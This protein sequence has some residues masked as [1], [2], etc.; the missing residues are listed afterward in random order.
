M[1]TIAKIHNSLSKENI[2][3]SAISWNGFNI[4]GDEKSIKEVKRLMH[5]AGCAA[6]LREMYQ[7]VKP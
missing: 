1:I 5:E 7:G 4:V 2:E 3:Y 6:S